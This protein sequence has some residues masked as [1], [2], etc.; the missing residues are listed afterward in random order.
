MLM[1]ELK[2][3]DNGSVKVFDVDTPIQIPFSLGDMKSKVSLYNIESAGMIFMPV[4][5][6]IWIGSFSM[7]RIR[8]T[9]YIKKVKD[10]AKTYP[11]ILNIYYFID[12]D[13]LDNQKKIDISNRMRIGDS[14]I[15]KSNRSTSILCFY[16]EVRC[17]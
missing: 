1:L 4:L 15:I 17:Y 11:H 9:Y 14:A 12:R 13:M 5:L 10:I 16:S 6:V 7:T 3:F 2:I 8:E